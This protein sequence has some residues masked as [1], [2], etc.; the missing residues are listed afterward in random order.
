MNPLGDLALNRQLGNLATS[1]QDNIDRQRHA[2][3][4]GV[5]GA[6]DAILASTCDDREKLARLEGIVRRTNAIRVE[7]QAQRRYVT[8]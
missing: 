7:L 2:L 6:V 4:P 5:L 8:T 1:S 3:P